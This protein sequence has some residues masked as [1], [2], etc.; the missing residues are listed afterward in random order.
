MYCDAWPTN[1]FGAQPSNTCSR[2]RTN[3]EQ[4]HDSFLPASLFGSAPIYVK[5]LVRAH[6]AINTNRT[7]D[8]RLLAYEEYSWAARWLAYVLAAACSRVDGVPIDA[9]VFDR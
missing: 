9:G 3:A 1:A 6:V 5:T 8:A 4:W 2:C 7:L